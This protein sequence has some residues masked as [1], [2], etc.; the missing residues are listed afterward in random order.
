MI[1][2]FNTMCIFHNWSCDWL[3]GSI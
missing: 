3:L 2:L 1:F